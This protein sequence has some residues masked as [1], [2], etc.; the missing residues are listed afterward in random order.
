MIIPLLALTLLAPADTPIEPVPEAMIELFVAAPEG[1]EL[2]ADIGEISA[3]VD[4]LGVTLGEDVSFVFTMAVSY[5]QDSAEE[6]FGPA[7]AMTMEAEDA[8]RAWA[9]D[10]GGR[11]ETNLP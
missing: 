6:G 4:T 5:W 9:F 2:C 7:A 1:V 11:P 3:M 8:F 10:C